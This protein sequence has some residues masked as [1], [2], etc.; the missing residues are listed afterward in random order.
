MVKLKNYLA[1]INDGRYSLARGE[2]IKDGIAIVR[3]YEGL[4][5]VKN[6]WSII[7]IASG[8]C[9]GVRC[10]SSKVKA[11]KRYEELSSSAKWKSDVKKARASGQYKIRVD[12]LLN[13]KQ[14]WRQSGYEF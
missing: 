9:A 13:E 3:L 1:R 12:E 7:D 8:L 10:Q 14:I 5:P 6:S 4:E 2:E 11:M